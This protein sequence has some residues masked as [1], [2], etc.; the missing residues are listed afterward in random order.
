MKKLILKDQLWLIDN[1]SPFHNTISHPEIW[2]SIRNQST[3][4]KFCGLKLFSQKHKLNLYHK[5]IKTLSEEDGFVSI[6]LDSHKKR[7]FNKKE[8]SMIIDL[9]G[10]GCIMLDCVYGSMLQLIREYGMEGAIERLKRIKLVCITHV[11]TKYYSGLLELLRLWYNVSNISNDGLNK[12]QM[13]VLGPQPIREALL[14]ISYLQ[15]Q[16]FL[17]I[18]CLL[19]ENHNLKTLGKFYKSICHRIWTQRTK[20]LNVTTKSRVDNKHHEIKLKNQECFNY[21]NLCEKAETNISETFISLLSRKYNDHKLMVSN[22][23]RK[24]DLTQI[25]SIRVANFKHS[26][27]ILLLSRMGWR[28][29]YSSDTR[30]SFNFIKVAH[31]S[32]LY[33]QKTI[34]SNYGVFY[35][36]SC[37]TKIRLKNRENQICNITSVYSSIARDSLVIRTHD[38]ANIERITPKRARELR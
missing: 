35:K 34:L 30:L 3:L 2:S 38:L 8:S 4:D 14:N 18:D 25:I 13:M 11:H 31:K 5:Y 10:K 23:A 24:L 1:F 26:F 28:L 12:E 15:P 17:F 27:G 21:S 20:K 37:R 19:T 9:P 22:L 36:L 32:T 33:I 6:L 29:V 7:H 16:N